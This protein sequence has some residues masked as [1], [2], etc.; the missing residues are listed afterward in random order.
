MSRLQNVEESRIVIL[1]GS[2]AAFGIHSDIMQEITGRSVV[3]MGL[4]VSLGLEFPLRCYLPH[5]RS[6]DVVIVSPEYHVLMKDAEQR[7]DRVLMGQL[8]EQWPSANDYLPSKPPVSWKQFMDHEGLRQTHRWV[9]RSIK[10]IRGRDQVDNIYRRSSFN[11]YGDLVAH[12]GDTASNL[13]PMQALPMPTEET[14]S[15][16]VQLLNQFASQ[17]QARGVSVYFCYPP[18]ARS[19]FQESQSAIHHTQQYL[20]RWCE[21]PN[22]N[23]PKDNVHEDTCF[24]DS[25]YHLNAET[26]RKQSIEIA[27]LIKEESASEIRIA[28]RRNKD[29]VPNDLYQSE[30]Q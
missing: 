19:T 9:H 24:F 25:S 8:I 15:Q 10:M 5:A 11:E 2:H 18:F 30:V 1:G 13:M 4:H 28:D 16:S 21:I 17:C 29:T 6:G 12:H 7:G 20:R 26:G 3:N 27:N 23:V 22:I 14:L